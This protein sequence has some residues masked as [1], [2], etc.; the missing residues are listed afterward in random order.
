MCAEYNQYQKKFVIFDLRDS[1]I[2]RLHYYLSMC[3]WDNV[4]NC[5]DI[6]DKFQ[7]FVNV[8]L[9]LMSQCIPARVVRLDKR[10]PSFVTPLVHMRLNRRRRLRRGGHL[11]AANALV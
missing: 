2:D 4:Y 1:N 8:L 6:N 5:V 7:N 9:I 10:D 11:N 3:S